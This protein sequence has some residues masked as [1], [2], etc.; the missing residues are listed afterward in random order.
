MRSVLV[1]AVDSSLTALLTLIAE[2][3]APLAVI[4]LPSELAGRH[5]DRADLRPAAADAGI[6]VHETADV[7]APGT[8]DLIS[9]I[10][11]DIVFVI[12]WSQICGLDLLAIPGEGMVGYHPSKLP[13]NRGRAVI[14]W[15]ILQGAKLTGSTLFWLNPGV[16]SGDILDQD[17]F[18]VGPRET[19][20]TLY[21]QHRSA[22][23]RMLRR[24]LP[25]LWAGEAP[26]SVQDD[27]EA[28]YCARRR[29]VDGLIDWNDS[30]LQVDRL[31]RA[32]TDPYP[33]AFT[34]YRGDPLRIW[35]GELIGP[36]PYWGL[37]G[38]VQALR[39][40]G[41]LV[42]CGDRGHVLLHDVQ[43]DPGPRG[44]AGRLLRLHERLG[45][46]K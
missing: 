46:D 16:D 14:P 21:A 11:P 20:T 24:T 40:G 17:V 2:D 43:L 6:P 38:Q 39:D 27:A 41:A 15:T 1:G 22:L 26:R 42:Q 36:A 25:K 45:E 10:E 28:T 8:L 32:T 13:E 3:S 7:N 5:S 9:R 31:V 19:A 37:P 44:P 34:W 4:T 18:S 12:G 35:S 29:P 30:A 23:R 33:G